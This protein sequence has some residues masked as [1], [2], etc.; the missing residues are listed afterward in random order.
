MKTIRVSWKLWPAFLVASMWCS[1]A[2]AHH[3]F[4]AYFGPSEPQGFITLAGTVREFRFTNPHGIVLLDVRD[5]QGA[6]ELWTLET[7]APAMLS[8]GGWTKASLT[9]GERI[10]VQGW[11]A[12]DGSRLLRL[13]TAK[14]A[15][16]TELGGPGR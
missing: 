1:L 5:A 12:R 6:E 10:V 2:C 11:R 3:S 7:L 13:Q 9:S 14:R 15:D 4:A 16:G 8:R